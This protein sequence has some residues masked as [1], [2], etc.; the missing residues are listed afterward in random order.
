VLRGWDDVRA[1]EELG[2]E[3]VGELERVDED[4]RETADE[5]REDEGELSRAD[6]RETELLEE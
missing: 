5:D 1:L 3:Y 6:G 2:R 4:G